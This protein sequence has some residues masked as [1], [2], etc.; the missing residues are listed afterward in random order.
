VSATLVRTGFGL[1]CEP[2]LLE[3][4]IELGLADGFLEDVRGGEG[5]I[6]VLEGPPG[7]G[8]TVLLR[9]VCERATKRGVEVL[10][11]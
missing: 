3:R 5:R 1:R 4:D 8:K 9:S 7:V 10:H 6:M 2:V 11:A